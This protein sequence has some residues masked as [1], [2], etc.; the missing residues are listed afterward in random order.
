[1]KRIKRTSNEPLI[2]HVLHGAGTCST[3]K[4]T[5]ESTTTTLYSLHYVS[6]RNANIPDFIPRQNK[7]LIINILFK[8]IHFLNTLFEIMENKKIN[9]KYG[10]RNGV[11]SI[12]VL[13][14][15]A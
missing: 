9:V 7:C 2:T 6:F 8:V 15:M 13:P 3:V 5:S 11:K 10:L 12:H 1:M 4:D 14:N